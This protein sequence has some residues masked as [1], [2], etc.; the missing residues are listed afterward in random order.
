[1]R[2]TRIISRV[3]VLLDRVVFDGVLRGSG[4]FIDVRIVIE[5]RGT[6]IANRLE[7]WFGGI[8]KP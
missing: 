7:R 3:M 5:Q 2:A 4:R 1:M 8:T 6:S